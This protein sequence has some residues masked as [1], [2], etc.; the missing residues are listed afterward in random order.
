MDQ[1]VTIIEIHDYIVKVSGKIK[2]IHN[3]RF[4]LEKN[5]TINAILISAT[6]KNAFLLVD[7]QNGEFNVNDTFV[8]VEGVEEVKTS[9]S[10]YGKIIDIHGNIIWP[11]TKKSAELEHFETNTI[12]GKPHKLMN[13]KTLNTQLFTG[14]IMID[15]LIPI[16][17]GQREAIIGNRQT[18]KTHIALNAI[19]N[20]KESNIKCIYVAI[21]AKKQELSHIYQI[22]KENRAIDYTIVI[23]A[24]A[25]SP[26]QQYLSPYVGMAHAENISQQNDVLIVFDDLTKHANIFRE[27]ALLIDN[28]VGKEAFPGDMFFAHSRLLER[29]GSFVNR[30]TITA[31]PIVKTIDNDITSLISSNIISITD[32]QIVT[33]SDLFASGKRPAIDINMSVSR[34]GSAVQTRSLT[35]ISGEMAKIYKAYRRQV[36]LAT[37]KYE[38]NKQMTRLLSQGKM[39]E[40]MFNQTGFAHYSPNLM[41][42][43]IKIISWGI[44]TD[45]EKQQKFLEFLDLFIVKDHTANK[46]FNLILNGLTKNDELVKDYFIQA[47]NQYNAI[48]DGTVRI[49]QKNN[50]LPI[51]ETTLKEIAKLLG[52]I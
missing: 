7:A 20:Q 28:P 4:Q 8:S 30:K 12:F 51:N 48:I 25:N 14:L 36:K 9:I 33:N 24:P 42:L 3:Q 34:T 11:I 43:T 39:I 21:G 41:I 26:F 50:F 52:D 46:I 29:S 19:I 22:L 15:L 37:L 47:I 2:Y 40:N 32:G 13:V 23:N 17:K 45:I 31:L 27:I 44:F 5:P 35:K 16:G 6:E 10:H 38:L 1:K 49:K 18:G